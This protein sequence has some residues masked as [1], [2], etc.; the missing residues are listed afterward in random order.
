LR[1]R[2]L[3]APLRLSSAAEALQVIEQAFGAYRAVV[4][5]LTES[6]AEAWAEVAD[7]ETSSGF[8]TELEFAICAGAK[9]GWVLDVD[10]AA[11]LVLSDLGAARLLWVICADTVARSLRQYSQLQ[12]PPLRWPNDRDRDRL[13]LSIRCGVK[14]IA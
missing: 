2:I 8:A 4:A 14:K 6:K 13:A 9:T 1:T 12:T 10:R 5:D 7:C 3:R 11:R